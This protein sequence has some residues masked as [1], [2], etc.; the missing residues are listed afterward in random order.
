MGGDL[1][2]ARLQRCGDILPGGVGHRRSLDAGGLVA[3]GNR[4]A[5]HD[6]VL[7]IRDGALQGRSG[8]GVRRACDDEGHE[9]GE[10]DS[11]SASS[12]GQLSGV[13]PVTN[14]LQIVWGQTRD[15]SG[16]RLSGVRPVTNGG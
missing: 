6:R 15:N 13:R 4:D 8:L 12:V 14:R 1:V 10:Y 9:G 16:S 11:H 5:G 3:D 2:P 7:R